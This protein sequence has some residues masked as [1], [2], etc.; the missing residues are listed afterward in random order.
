MEITKKVG[1]LEK[2]IQE[3]RVRITN[4]EEVLKNPETFFSNIKNKNNTN[5]FVR[6]TEVNTGYNDIY[7]NLVGITNKYPWSFISNINNNTNQNLIGPEAVTNNDDD[8]VFSTGYN[9]DNNLE[10]LTESNNDN[11]LTVSKKSNDSNNTSAVSSAANDD[12]NTSAI[13]TRANDDSNN[14]T[15]LTESNNNINS[16]VSTESNNDNNSVVSIE[17]DNDN[18]SVV[19]IESN[20]DNNSVV[21]IESNNDNNSVVSIESNNDKNSVVSI[22]SNNDNNS[23]VSIES[24]NDNNSVVSIESNNDNNNLAIS[25]PSIDNTNPTQSDHINFESLFNDISTKQNNTEQNNT[26]NENLIPEFWVNKILTDFF[27]DVS[28]KNLNTE[29]WIGK[30]LMGVLA[31]LLVFIALITFAKA[32][33]P[34]LTNT[35]KIILMFATSIALTGTG[36]VF[37]K[38]KPENTVYKAILACGSASIYI[39]ILAT[40]IYFKAVDFIIMYVLIALWALLIIFLKK[41]KDDK[42]FF[43][44][45]N[46]GYFV[47]ILYTA[48]LKDNSLILPMLVYVI[49]IGVF[50][51]IMYWKNE[52]K[53]YIQSI[54]NVIALLLFQTIMLCIFKKITEVIII[55][56]AVLLTV[57]KINKWENEWENIIFKTV[58]AFGSA[59]IYI[60]ILTTGIYFKATS[61]IFMYSVITV[62]TVFI[63]FLHVFLKE[64]NNNS[65]LFFVIGNLGYLV[66]IIFTKELKD[67]SLILPLLVYVIMVGVFYQIMYWKNEYQRHTQNIINVISL[68]IFQAIMLFLFKKVTEVIIIEMVA[69]LIAT[70]VIKT[71]NDIFKI[72]L[73]LGSSSIYISILITGIYFKAINLIYMYS[74][75]APWTVFIIFLYVFHNEDNNNGWLFFVIGNLGYLVSVIFTKELKDRSLILPLLVYVIMVGVFYQIMYWKNEYHRHTQNIINVISLLIFQVIMLFLFEKVTEVIIIEMVAILIAT[76]IIKTENDIF[77]I[78]L[79]LGSSSIYT[80]I[81]ITGI[82]FKTIDLIYMYSVIVLWEIFIIFLHVFLKEDNNNSWLFFVIG[83]IGYFVSVI[84]TNELKDGTLIL[85]LLAYVIMVGVFYQIMYWKNE[86]QRHT[87]NIINVISLLIFQALMQFLFEKVTE[88]II[89][90]MVAILIATKIIKTE[91]LI[92]RIVLALGSSSIYISILLTSIY[93]QNLDLIYMYGLIVLWEIFIIFLHVFLKEDNNNRGVFFVIGNIGYFVSVI[94]TNELKDRSLILP[95]LVYVIMVGVFYQ[96]MF[97]KNKYHRHTQNVINVISLLLFQTIMLLQFGRKTEVIIIEIVVMVITTIGFLV[98]VLSDF[99][100]HNKVHFYVAIVNIVAY[101]IAYFFLLFTVYNDLPVVLSFAVFIFPAVVLEILNMYWRSK[102]LAK[103]ESFVNAIFSGGLFYAA[104]TILSMS[105]HFLFYSGTLLVVYSMIAIYGII[106]KDLFFKVQGWILVYIFMVKGM[107]QF[108]NLTFTIVATILTLT[109][110]I[111]EGIVINDSEFFKIISYIVLLEWIGKIGVHV[112]DLKIVSSNIETVNLLIYGIMALLNM[113]LILT[114]FYKTKEKDENGEREGEG[115]KSHFVLDIFN[116]VFMFYN[117]YKMSILDD[118]SLK[119][120]Y[121]IILFVLGSINLPV[122]D[123]G[124]SKRYM[125]SAIKFYIIIWYSLNAFDAPSYVISI[126]IIAF[127]V[128]CVAIGFSNKLIGKELRVFGLVMTLIFVIKLIIIDI[129]FDSSVLKALSYLISGILCFGISAI[130]NYF[131]SIKQKTD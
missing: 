69:I 87:Q 57:A 43:V 5:P 33:L 92:F 60:S 85:P 68:L 99:F 107:F 79:A 23:A 28:A 49:M 24:N 51:Q 62:W 36:F 52:H 116:L 124:A 55:E 82:F 103:Y 1:E 102:H 47:S 31:S 21:S 20:N 98:Y 131:D 120:V 46:L 90:E 10:V 40:G 114:K 123:K 81:L 39:S 93:F 110:L 119:I 45:G 111:T 38:K 7:H 109:S 34:Y 3:L 15:V 125:Y 78:V 29:S 95:L 63:I 117:C 56:M 17:S 16:T 101:F 65:W 115:R 104:A 12:N 13:T 53:R 42:L 25:T 9:N 11:N 59:C 19:S 112:Y 4:L 96:I 67:R 54:I 73:A 128:V 77:K 74:V 86:Y 106:K 30:I 100:N 14:S 105:D 32:L 118:N 122:K 41:D 89:I 76:K 8:S 58:L 6:L 113:V 35:I 44:I 129:N 88:V 66:S 71:K 75:I 22:E 127:S 50:Y 126:C 27:S 91:Y 26:S 64:D 121:T 2:E 72:V 94:F 84:F 37:S 70:K 61:M 130:Y 48:E 80:S 108:S 97:W 83:N 18:N